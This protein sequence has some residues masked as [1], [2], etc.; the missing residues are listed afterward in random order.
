MEGFHWCWFS[1]KVPTLSGPS[2]TSTLLG[3]YSS[4]KHVV[5]QSRLTY[6]C[7][8]PLSDTIV[9]LSVSY[10]YYS[11]TTT[12]TPTT[13][14]TTTTPTTT[15]TTTTTTTNTTTLLLLLLVELTLERRLSDCSSCT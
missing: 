3:K 14:T 7:A 1:R 5:S 9:R 4:G 8:A 2:P 13:T 11:T 15:T 12:T 6:I 10:Y